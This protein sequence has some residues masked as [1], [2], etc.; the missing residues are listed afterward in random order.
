M[1]EYVNLGDVCRQQLGMQC[2][3]GSRYAN[4][5]YPQYISEGLRITGDPADYH[6]MKI[7]RDDVQEFVRR[8]QARRVE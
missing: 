1:D 2:Q 4:P 5:R 7:H 3:Y 8:V 6:F